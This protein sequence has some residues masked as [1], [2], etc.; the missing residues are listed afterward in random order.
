MLCL[1]MVLMLM[2]MV[3]AQSSVA[4][5][6]RLRGQQH[7]YWLAYFFYGDVKVLVDIVH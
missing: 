7:G 3:S 2:V 1:R 5:V 4:V 6:S